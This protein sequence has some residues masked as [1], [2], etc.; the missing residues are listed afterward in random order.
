[1]AET[2]VVS[3]E[4]PLLQAETGERS[5]TV[6]T[7]SVQNLPVAGRN[8]ASFATLTPG[9]IAQGSAAVRADGARTNYL[10]DGISSVNTG[11]NQQGIQVNPD[12]IAEVRVVATAYQAEYGRT[13]G[14]QIAGVTKSGTNRFSGSVYDIE[15]RTAWNT[16]SWA[17]QK[18]GNPKPI[19]DQRDWGYT[20]GGPLGKPGGDND[21]F[22]FYSQQ[23][24]PRKTGGNVNQFRVPTAA[25]RNGDFSA[26]TDNTGALFNLIRDSS[27]GLP[28]T[29]ANRSGCF[30]DGGTLGKIPQNRLYPIGLQVLNLYPMPNTQGLNYNLEVQQPEVENNTYLHVVRVDYKVTQDLR[31][32]AKFAG[33]DAT[34]NPIPGSLPGFNDLLFRFPEIYVPSATVDIHDQPDDHPRRHMGVDAGEPTRQRSDEP[35]HRP[36]LG[37]ACR[38][39]DPLPQ[40]RRRSGRLVPGEGAQGDGRALLRRRPA[41]DAPEL[42]LGQPRRQRASE[43]RVSAVPLYA[44]HEGLCAQPHEGV[45]R[46]YVQVRLSVAGQPEEAE[47]RHGDERRA[48]GRRRRST[49]VRTATTP[50]IRSSGSPTRRWASSPRLR[51]RTRSSKA[52]TS[53]TTRTS[54]CRTTGR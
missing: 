19:A 23:F 2:V 45:G 38:L 43:Q 34:V 1:M 16:N 33:Q 9:V 13:S 42:Q 21:F 53:T 39:P 26:T 40:Q 54:T 3:A 49:S 50:S 44:E 4:A 32:S 11:G 12:A 24:Q 6:P 5:F 10:L 27:T 8:F 35:Q 14:I 18:N 52:T 47:R 29:A 46:A 48:A 31:I 7:E 22:F 15:R 51:S 30:Q 17:N 41:A 25:E 37:R 36:Q 28:C 20:V